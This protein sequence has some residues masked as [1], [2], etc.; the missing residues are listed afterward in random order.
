LLLANV[1]QTIE[2]ARERLQEVLGSG[3]ALECLRSN[4]AAQ[5]GDPRV[6]DAPNKFLPLVSETV[7]VESP[8]SGF[9]T[10]VDT[11]EIGHAIAAIGGG[12][13]RIEDT[14]NPT[15]GFTSELKLGDRV[16]AGEAI[17]TVYCADD[18]A[19]REAARRIQ[20]AYHLGEDPPAQA[21][22]LVKEI[23]N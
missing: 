16:A 5:G 14:V 17:G 10:R 7:K 19:A 18:A 11:T 4:I 23:I 13:V 3:E 22:K 2:A 8:R 21:L 1:E 15:V 20:A 6:C 12:R 9:I